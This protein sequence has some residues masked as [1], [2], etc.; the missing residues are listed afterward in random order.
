MITPKVSTERK[1]VKIDKNGTKHWQVDACPKCGGTGVYWSRTDDM[2]CWRCGGTGY[3]PYIV[4]EYTPEHADVLAKKQRERGLKKNKERLPQ[5]IKYRGFKDENSSIFIV[6]G[7]TY[8]IKKQLSEAGARFHSWY[9]WYFSDAKDA[10][11]WDTTEIKFS[12]IYTINEYFTVV[13]KEGAG[14]IIE[15]AKQKTNSYKEVGA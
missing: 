1:L 10:K 6:A 13:A 5:E 4:K 15:K 12:D 8:P 2:T 7:N 3:S 14:E 11:D 9:G